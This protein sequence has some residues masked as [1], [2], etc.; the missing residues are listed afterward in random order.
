M[1][2]VSVFLGFLCLFIC[3]ISCS[4]TA[5]NSTSLSIKA[6]GSNSRALNTPIADSDVEKYS[7]ILS[8]TSSDSEYEVLPGGLLYIEK[9]NPGTYTIKAYAKNSGEE[10]IA[11]GS[12]KVTVASGEN[13]DVQLSVQKNSFENIQSYDLRYEG[14]AIEAEVGNTI[15]YSVLTQNLFVE[16]TYK[17]GYKK[18]V[19]IDEVTAISGMQVLYEILDNTGNLMS[20]STFDSEMSSIVVKL[21]T[22]D[23]TVLSE[24]TVNI[25]FE[26]IYLIAIYDDTD[27]IRFSNTSFSRGNRTLPATPSKSGFTFFGWFYHNGDTWTRLS[28]NPPESTDKIP[29]DKLEEYSTAGVIKAHW[30]VD[31]VSQINTNDFSATDYP[32]GVTL[33]F[34]DGFSDVA[35][36]PACMSSFNTA[37]IN[38]KVDMS[39]SGLTVLTYTSGGSTVGTVFKDCTKLISIL[40]PDALTAIPGECFSG[41]SGL[42]E[43]TIPP[44]CQTLAT[45]CFYNCTGLTEITIPQNCTELGS[46]CLYG[47]ENLTSVTFEDPEGWQQG[48]TPKDL[49]DPSVNAQTFKNAQYAYTKS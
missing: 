4:L 36:I 27:T 32:N 13:T 39:E 14:T 17:S 20:S 49:S 11:Y 16:L 6:P 1:R 46:S 23:S 3:F 21:A 47:C 45:K 28:S 38:V 33:V 2:K 48:G 15:D 22:S 41:C 26:V 40:L 19:S 31:D 7:I 44:S 9:I 24:A 8:G 10:C 43:I 18:T 5:G 37:R 30:T 42:T 34:T 35:N 29:A 12:Q 25:E